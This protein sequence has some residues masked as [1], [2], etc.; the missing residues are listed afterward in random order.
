MLSYAA[1]RLGAALATV[2]GVLTLVFAVLSAAPGDPARLAA[3]SGHRISPAAAHAFRAAWG[4]DQ[5]V[6][7]RFARWVGRAVRLDFG[8]SLQDGRDVRDR[9][10][11]TL[12]LTAA[13]NV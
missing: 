10:L 8:R 2:A 6:P 11:E 9:I 7:V 1:R 3:G 12:P 13:I 5:P 4:L